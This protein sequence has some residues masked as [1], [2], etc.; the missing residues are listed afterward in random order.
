MYADLSLDLRS[1][2]EGPDLKK[3]LWFDFA[4]HKRPP[5]RRDAVEYLVAEH[6]VS[7]R[8]ACEA[9]GLPRATWYQPPRDR[10]A[11]DGEVIDALMGITDAHRRWGFWKCFQRLRLDGRWWNHKRVYRV[12]CQLGLNHKRRTKKRIPMRLRQPLETQPLP[13]Q[14]WALDFMSDALYVGRRFRTLNVL[15]ES[16]REALDIEIDPPRRIDRRA[17]DSRSGAHG[18]EGH[19]LRQRPGADIAGLRRLVRAP[20]DRNSLHPAR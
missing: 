15:D 14:V 4:H 7:I 6:E 20:P 9:V 8:E 19:P 11:K 13:N 17:G 18:A 10:L 16:V 3:A 5:E 2:A 12:Y 1:G